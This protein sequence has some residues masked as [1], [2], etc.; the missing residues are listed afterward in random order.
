MGQGDI[1]FDIT[2]AQD[3]YAAL[4][5]VNCGPFTIYSQLNTSQSSNTS[6]VVESLTNTAQRN[7]SSFSFNSKQENLAGSILTYDVFIGSSFIDSVS[8]P[9]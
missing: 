6:S 9:T 4:V 2:W 5:G 3:S 1:Y 7:Q 8:S